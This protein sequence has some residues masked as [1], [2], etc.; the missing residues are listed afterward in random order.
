MRGTIEI[1]VPTRQ[2]PCVS[3]QREAIVAK[4]ITACLA[5]ALLLC[6]RNANA[7]APPQLIGKSIIVSYT[8]NFMLRRAGTQA[9]FHAESVQHQMSIYVSSVGRPFVRHAATSPHGSGAGE[10]VGTGG[11]SREGGA[12][13]VQFQ[14][15]SL[16]L[17]AE[18]GRSATQIK[19]NFDPGFTACTANA[20]F[21]R[22]AG[23]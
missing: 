21:G 18:H 6:H 9:P 13:L 19:I 12:R 22:D 1:V 14:G 20:I 10:V 5:L 23:A 7:A 15:T 11:P 4:T 16:T 8:Y 2:A 3:M 17:L